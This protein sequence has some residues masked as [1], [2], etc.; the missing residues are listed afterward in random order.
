VA[1]LPAG[2]LAGRI[3]ATIVYRLPD[4]VLAYR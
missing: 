2:G 3:G 4:R 1:G